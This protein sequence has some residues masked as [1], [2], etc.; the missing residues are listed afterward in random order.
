MVA[1]NYIEIIKPQIL[2]NLRFY[3]YSYTSLIFKSPYQ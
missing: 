2:T 3:D 1:D